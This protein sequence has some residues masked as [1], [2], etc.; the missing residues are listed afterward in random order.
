M[1]AVGTVVS[2][3]DFLETLLAYEKVEPILPVDF[4]CLR[5]GIIS[6]DLFLLNIFEI[7][8]WISERLCLSYTQGGLMIFDPVR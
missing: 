6:T 2:F 4:K 5:F 7:F 8:D 3:T 1:A